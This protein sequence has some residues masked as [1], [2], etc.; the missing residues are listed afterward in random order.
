MK[1]ILV[2]LSLNGK[3]IATYKPTEP[4]WWITSFNPSY[5]EIY[6]CH[7]T[8][9]FTVDFSDNTDMYE[10]FSEADEERKYP[11]T[12]NDTKHTATLVF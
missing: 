8:A 12:F 6:V 7:L 10:A 1:N 5:Q 4:Q 2:M 3:T 11:W 9:T